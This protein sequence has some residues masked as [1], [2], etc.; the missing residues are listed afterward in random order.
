MWNTVFTRDTGFL[1][2]N[3]MERFLS[4]ELRRVKSCA[5]KKARIDINS[6]SETGC[7]YQHNKWVYY[8]L[9]RLSTCWFEFWVNEIHK[10]SKYI[11][12]NHLICCKIMLCWF[13]RSRWAI[14]RMDK[15]SQKTDRWKWEKLLAYR[16][17][18]GVSVKNRYRYIW[19]LL[20]LHC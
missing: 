5:Q 7:Q 1:F 17:I 14:Y 8:R 3:N 19:K 18:Q 13:Q 6:A 15:S 11:I 4:I 20:P 16:T 2:Q 10:L 12:M 9:P